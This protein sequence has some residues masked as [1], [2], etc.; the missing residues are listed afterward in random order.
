MADFI[1]KDG[2]D[3]PA[4]DYSKDHD[5]AAG[6]LADAEMDDDEAVP[7]GLKTAP[8]SSADG[9][10]DDG[11]DDSAPAPAVVVDGA[12]ATAAATGV[13]TASVAVNNAHHGGR[14]GTAATATTTTTPSKE[15]HSLTLDQ[16]RALR[17]WANSQVVRPSHKA[18]I[19][20]FA[21]EYGLSIS[22]S[23]VSHSLSPKYA[24]LD[25]DAQLSGSRLR[26]GN[27][28]DVEKLVLLWHSEM[29]NRGRQP[30]N[31][32]LVQK[33]VAIFEQLPRYEGEKAPNFS[34]GWVHRFKKRYGLLMRR[35]RRTAPGPSGA[36]GS[37]ELD[38]ISYLVDALPR[39]TPV[40]AETP[41]A[42]IRDLFSR[43][44]GIDTSMA[45][46]ARVRDEVV[47]IQTA[48]AAA[49][50]AAAA[51]PAPAPHNMA[52]AAAAVA[53]ANPSL[54]AGSAA[55]HRA[56][57]DV[58]GVVGGGGSVQASSSSQMD[59]GDD[60]DAEVALQNALRQIQQEETDADAD[61]A[62]PEDN[63]HHHIEDNGIPIN[64]NAGAAPNGGDFRQQ[65]LQP[66]QETPISQPQ[67]NQ[68]HHQL[69]QQQHPQ[70]HTQPLPPPLS[71][72]QLQQHQRQQQHHLHHH[73]Q[74][75][76]A[77]PQPPAPPP[78]PPQ[79]QQQPPQL[80][81]PASIRMH[82]LPVTTPHFSHDSGL[83]LTP[84]PS[85]A[86]AP[87]SGEKPVRCPFCVNTRMLRSIKEAVEHMS[88]HVVVE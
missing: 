6:Q 24:R 47:S 77:S 41:A 26:F 33:A 72:P 30:S 85:S 51:V 15:R 2:A 80:N 19:E 54:G 18:C 17:R 61:T 13:A 9:Y 73:Q 48:A 81:T 63:E 65:Q 20:W 21:S 32:E 86:P 14:G 69:H 43:V 23:T 11:D 16:R 12:G 42:I 25:S 45:T 52:I 62:M 75:L 76:P 46:C 66:A 28:P 27:W 60:D 64:R 78:Q 50:A 35:Q 58:V 53:A 79:Q 49:A 22:Q 56:T 83:K 71:Q 8:S 44:I 55:S 29:V 59:L 74:P 1:S 34:P 82:Q 38:D 87:A 40:S 5:A 57:S 31:E 3:L 37:D 36:A 88:T 68:Q 7:S 67:A 70:P 4:A 39:F 10:D 84:I